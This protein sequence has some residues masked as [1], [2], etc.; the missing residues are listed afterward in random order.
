MHA[1]PVSKL[2]RSYS[3]VITSFVP[4]YVNTVLL[5]DIGVATRFRTRGTVIGRDRGEYKIYHYAR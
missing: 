5:N 1:F 4:L 2:L 3:V